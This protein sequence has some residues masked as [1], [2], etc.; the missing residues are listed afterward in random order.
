M[1]VPAVTDEP[2]YL[3]KLTERE[4]RLI[5]RCLTMRAVFWDQL[6]DPVT[7]TAYRNL[8]QRFAEE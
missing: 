3:Y 8:A 7:A 6:G 1:K 5:C 4:R 2:L